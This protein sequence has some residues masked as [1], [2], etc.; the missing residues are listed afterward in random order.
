MNKRLIICLDGTWNTPDNGSNPTNVVKIMRGIRS[1]D[2]H[3]TPQTVFYCPGVGT[4]GG[5]FDRIVGGAFGRGLERNVQDGYRFLANNYE[6][7]DEIYIFGFSRGAYTAR[8]LGGFI[9]ICSLLKNGA[10]DRLPEA[11]QIYRTKPNKR[12]IDQLREINEL[13]HKGVRIKCL[14]VWDTVGALGIPGESLQWVNRGKYEFHD[15]KLGKNVDFA[16]H[17]IAI[18]EKRGPF[19]PAPWQKPDHNDYK[20]VEQV[21]FPGVHSNI[22]GGYADARLSDLA[23][24]WMIGRVTASTKL[25]FDDKYIGDELR[26]DYVGEIYESRGTLYSV[27]KFLP[28]LRLIG[29]NAVKSSWLRKLFPRT[30][31]PDGTGEFINEMIHWSAVKRVG[32][33]SIF[34]GRKVIYKPQNLAAA[35]DQ[36]PVVER[37]GSVR[38]P[39]SQAVC[40]PSTISTERDTG[41]SILTN[42]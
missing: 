15:T 11:W 28:Y 6:P 9:S 35:I 23:L 42:S 18:D 5:V 27:S 3:G 2:D 19:A 29:Q 22:G 34:D 26:G 30:N 10:M 33:E 12:N 16:F 40:T 17:A 14:G 41:Q 24:E 31:R 8:S 37:D 32:K 39:T 7:G 38:Q 13:A 36:L 1:R 20:L 21:W 25:A 4:D